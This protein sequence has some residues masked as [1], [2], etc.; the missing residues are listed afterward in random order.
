MSLLH[1][2]RNLFN[3]DKQPPVTK[4]E[5]KAEIPAPVIP[6]PL[7]QDIPDKAK[8]A[9]AGG[10]IVRQV[11]DDQQPSPPEILAQIDWAVKT[12]KTYR[13]GDLIENRYKVEEVMSGAMGYVYIGRDARQQITFA[14]KQPKESMLAD[15]DLFSRVLQ[16]ADSWTGLGMHPNIAYCYF[17]KQ[18]EDVP[19]IFIEYVDGGSLEEWISDRRCADYKVGLDMAIQFCHGLERA[20]E[21]GM[22]HRDIKP[23]NILVTN[24]GLVKVTDFG[25]AGGIKVGGKVGAISGDQQGTRMGAMMGTQAY[26]SPEQFR[27]PRQKSAEAPEGVW[28]ESDVYSFGVCLWEMSCGRRPREISI[29]VTGDTL[30]PQ[31]LRRDIPAGL[32]TLLLSSVDLD[33]EKRPQDFSELRE[34]LNEIYRYLYSSDAPHYQLELHDTTADEL[35]NQGYSYYEL[36]KKEE[37]RKCFEAAVEVNNTHPE[38]V[39]NLALLQWRGGEI[40]D[41]DALKRVRNCI[42]HT[43]ARKKKISEFLAYIHVERF[44]SASAKEV[45][46]LMDDSD[47]SSASL[48]VSNVNENDKE[49]YKDQIDTVVKVIANDKGK[50]KEEVTFREVIDKFVNDLGVANKNRVQRIF[51]CLALGWTELNINNVLIKEIEGEIKNLYEE[52]FISEK[53]CHGRFDELFGGIETQKMGL[54]RTFE[55]YFCSVESVCL[56]AGGKYALSGSAY[57]TLKLWEV[58]TG[59]CLRTFEGHS[60]TYTSVSLSADG[61][62][63]LSGSNDKTLQL[64]EVSTGQCLRTFEGH[65]GEVNSV[66]LIAYGRYALSG[67]EDNSLKLWDVLT[68]KCLHTFEG[69][70]KSVTSVSLSADWKYALSGSNDNTLKL[71]ELTTGKCLCTFEGHSGCVNSVSLSADGKYALSGSND[72]TLKLW[73]LTTGKCLRTFVCHNNSVKSVSLSADGRYALSGSHDKTLKLWDVNTGQCLRTFNGHSEWVNSVSLSADGKYALSGSDDKTLKLWEI[74]IKAHFYKSEL[75]VSDFKAFEEIK[76]VQD[77]LKLAIQEA[78]RMMNNGNNTKAFTALCSA[79][80]RYDFKDDKE[81]LIVYQKL[82]ELSIRKT[83]SFAYA[84]KSFEGHSEWVNSVSLSADGKYALS[85]SRDHTLKLWEVSTGQCLRIIKG[86][87]KSFTSASLSADGKYAISG[88]YDGALKLWEVSTGQC[89]RT[90][91]GHS[92]NVYSVSLSADGNF[93]ISGSEL[94]KTMKLWEISTGQ[95]LR[96]WHNFS[97]NSVCLSADGRYALSGGWDKTL[98]VWEVSTGQCLRTFEGHSESVWSVCL[99]AD[100]KYALSGSDDEMLKLW[101]VST[102]Q[103]LRTFQGHSDSVQSVSLSADGNFAI[104][105]GRDHTLKLWDVSTGQ[106]LHTFE[107]HSNKVTSVCLSADGRYAISGSEDGT[108]KLWRLIWKLEFDE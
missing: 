62:Y 3:Q 108:I 67:S 23:R 45:L 22:I 71:W 63:A 10:T 4:A 21:R 103:C 58:S 94:D 35:N 13:T 97:E 36:G 18:I 96:T 79:W 87:S 50:N 17:V 52:F 33:R 12:A 95:C 2:L 88:A 55:G 29:G 19:H 102:G 66:S 83:F 73:E 69:H 100:G 41:L 43:S 30:D 31:S 14:I 98:K 92:D 51:N 61:K 64:W 57:K 80:E 54:V 25:I 93:A 9:P 11:V 24:E 6:K 91:E 53:V 85:G 7:H 59:Q 72:N 82:Y 106:C 42:N 104:S 70:S 65:S 26:M 15:R 78:R 27:D 84:K 47:I 5:A 68:G 81:L 28:Y 75:Q 107:G 1:D 90:F 76:G 46:N 39:F 77:E 56:S 8:P 101:D 32:R 44:D 40:D 48:I 34:K 99:S 37:A 49:F 60:D 20:H 38:A 16:E 89:L 105:G 86:H 74:N